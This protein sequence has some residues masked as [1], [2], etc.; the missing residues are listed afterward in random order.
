VIYDDCVLRKVTVRVCSGEEH[1]SGWIVPSIA[2]G[3]F[4]CLTAKHCVNKGNVRLFFITDDNKE[5]PLGYTDIIES[6]DEN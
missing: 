1:G 6:H 3:R 2:E 5:E 4:Y